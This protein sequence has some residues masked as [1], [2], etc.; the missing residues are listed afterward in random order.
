VPPTES[1]RLPSK[2]PGSSG[3]PLT[4]DLDA[5]DPLPSLDGHYPVSSPLRRSPPQPAASVLSASG[6]R[7]C[8][9][10][11][12]IGKLVPTVP[13]R[14]LCPTHAPYTP[15]AVRTVLQAPGG[16]IPGEVCAP[17]L[18]TPDLITTRLRRFA[19]ARLLD[20]HLSQVVPGTFDPTFTTAAFGRSG[21]DWPIPRGPPSSST[22]LYSTA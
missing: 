6:C 12:R 21:S 18:T 19:C 11:F 1:C 10:S 9:F 13:R 5:G 8:A 2:T 14:S 17:V 4:P 3:F 20:P 22:Q 7:P 15:A 16:L